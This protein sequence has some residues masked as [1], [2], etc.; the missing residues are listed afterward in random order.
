MTFLRNR[1]ATSILVEKKSIAFVTVSINSFLNQFNY[2][3]SN[4][5]F[6][7]SNYMLLIYLGR[8]DSSLNVLDCFSVGFL[9]K[10]A[11]LDESF[12][13]STSFMLMYF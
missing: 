11:V 9:P 12:L 2:F 4:E 5:L 7:S 1:G 3:S 10:V 6:L 13:V 8:G